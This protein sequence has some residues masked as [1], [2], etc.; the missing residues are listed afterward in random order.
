MPENLSFLESLIW[1]LYQGWEKLQG[2]HLCH[3][4]SFRIGQTPVKLQE[5]VEFHYGLREWKAIIPNCSSTKYG[6]Y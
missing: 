6:S 2:G 4:Q 5:V 3:G 1:K